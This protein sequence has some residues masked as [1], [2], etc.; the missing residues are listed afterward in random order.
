MKSRQ[1]IQILKKTL[2][3]V[4]F[5][6]TIL[7]LLFCLEL[8]NFLD[9]E[10]TST[11]PFDEEEKILKQNPEISKFYTDLN[12]SLE[13]LFVMIMG[14]GFKQFKIFL[15]FQILGNQVDVSYKC[16]EIL[17]IAKEFKKSIKKT[18][19]RFNKLAFLVHK[20]IYHLINK[21]YKK[22]TKEEIPDEFLETNSGKS[23]NDNIFNNDNIRQP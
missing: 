2:T 7:N 20:K 13:E 8:I 4:N 10:K 17:S 23:S 18:F 22:C 9:H 6:K 3:K 14:E 15:K 5:F 21:K 1:P 19:K 11:V 12:A 16:E